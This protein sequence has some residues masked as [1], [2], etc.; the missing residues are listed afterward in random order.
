[1]GRGCPAT[2]DGAAEGED[3]SEKE[4]SPEAGQG[5]A[6]RPTARAPEPTWLG[7]VRSAGDGRGYGI[8]QSAFCRLMPPN[9]ADVLTI[10]LRS[11]A[12]LSTPLQQLSVTLHPRWGR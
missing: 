10:I 7:G 5:L 8:R 2:G 3:G 4:D 11:I 12:T 6:H 1:M 9:S